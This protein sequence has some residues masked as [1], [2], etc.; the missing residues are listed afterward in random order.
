M[1]TKS[2]SIPVTEGSFEFFARNFV[3][4]MADHTAVYKL[5]PAELTALQTQL[6]D[7]ENKS[8][9]ATTARDAAKAATEAKDAARETL[10]EDLR[11]RIRMIQADPSISE[12]AKIEAGIR[13][14]KATRTPVPAPHTFPIGNV[15]ASDRLEHTV[16]YSD[17]ATPT[18][19]ARP[20]GVSACEIYV[21]V[22]DVA[23]T[24]PKQYRFVKLATRSSEV[25]TF[26]AVDGGKTA[27]YLLRWVNTKGEP[28]P[29]SVVASATIPAV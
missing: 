19:R 6:Q 28:G 24:D 2:R 23:P 5:T 29:W 3:K 1:A 13:P 14:H 21:A 7:W 15:I 12:E 4:Q 27:N 25:V 10:E 8:D 11:V 17:A 16:F 22:A 9:A 20:Y 26:E 18:K